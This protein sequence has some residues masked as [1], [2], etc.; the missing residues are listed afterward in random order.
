[1]KYVG[2]DWAREEHRCALIDEEGTV[3]AQWA[4][5][6]DGPGLD[7]LVQRLAAEASL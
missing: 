2:I 1:M 3:Q 4:V 6:H 5:V 7:G